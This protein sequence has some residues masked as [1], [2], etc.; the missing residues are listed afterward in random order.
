METK[1]LITF[2]IFGLSLLI[3]SCILLI[4][5]IYF[6]SYLQGYEFKRPSFYKKFL[7]LSDPIDK[8]EWILKRTECCLLI[9]ILNY[10]ILWDLICTKIKLIH[11]KNKEKFGV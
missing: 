9:P 7:E 3:T 6:P 4:K 11:Y 2:I 1:I 8:E 10:F 5:L